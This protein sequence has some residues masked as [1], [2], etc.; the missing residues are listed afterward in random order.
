MHCIHNCTY[1]SVVTHVTVQVRLE[2][3]PS[4]N[5]IVLHISQSMEAVPHPPHPVVRIFS[6]AIPGVLQVSFDVQS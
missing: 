1:P 3:S 6:I 2:E 4:G 5:Y